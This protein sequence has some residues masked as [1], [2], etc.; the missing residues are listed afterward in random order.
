MDIVAELG[1]SLDD[2]VGV[3]VRPMLPFDRGFAK[4]W[5]TVEGF[6]LKSP[7][8]WED[9]YDITDIKVLDRDWET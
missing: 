1:T 2:G 6:L 9:Y 5:E 4:V 3:T 7:S 8:S